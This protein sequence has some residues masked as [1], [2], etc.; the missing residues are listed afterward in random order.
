MRTQFLIVTVAAAIG[1]VATNHANACRLHLPPF[2][3]GD[4]PITRQHQ[5]AL[6]AAAQVEESTVTPTLM[7]AGIPGAMLAHDHNRADLSKWFERLHD[8][9]GDLC[10]DGSEAMHLSEVDW[11][12]DGNHYRV[13]VPT[14]SRGFERAM[15]GATN[16]ETEWV[17]VPD[18]AV[19]DEPNRANVTLVWPLYGPMGVSVRCFMPGTMA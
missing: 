13:R 6:L 19:I 10:C 1:L 7:L 12:I 15:A 8:R 18:K 11:E 17:Y 4:F 2:E 14:T 5:V 3:L 9:K 16:V